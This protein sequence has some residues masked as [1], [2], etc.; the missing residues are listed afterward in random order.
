MCHWHV[1]TTMLPQT[2]E[3]QLGG[4]SRKSVWE[5]SFLRK[6]IY[7]LDRILEVEAFKAALL[8]AC[9][10]VWCKL[11]KCSNS[12]PQDFG[13]I[14][15]V[16]RGHLICWQL[17]GDELLLVLG[18]WTLLSWIPTGS[19]APKENFLRN[20]WPPDVIYFLQ[21]DVADN[22]LGVVNNQ[23]VPQSLLWVPESR[24]LNTSCWRL[25]MAMLITKDDVSHWK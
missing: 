25:Q 17:V 3:R 8:T 11:L 23:V 19:S 10:H 24:H 18:P 16:N 9:S 5:E 1:T 20:K 4:K 15:F 22:I 6:P 7:W 13:I 21:F 12:S 2:N 14:L